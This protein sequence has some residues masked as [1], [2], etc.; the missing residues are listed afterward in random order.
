MLVEFR[1]S[2]DD[3]DHFNRYGGRLELKLSLYSAIR[4]RHI[5]QTILATRR[6]GQYI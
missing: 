2:Y 5:L 1:H 6:N 3:F 4:T